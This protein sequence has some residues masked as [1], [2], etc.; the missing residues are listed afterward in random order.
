MLSIDTRCI[1]T[2][3]K[4][5]QSARPKVDLLPHRSIEMYEIERTLC[6][7]SARVRVMMMIHMVTCTIYIIY[8]GWVEL[9][10]ALYSQ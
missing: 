4:T 8:G 2:S 7:H 5:A 9:D 1:G 3:G 10:P 6:A